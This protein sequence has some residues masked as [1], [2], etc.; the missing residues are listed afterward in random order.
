[1]ITPTKVEPTSSDTHIAGVASGVWSVQ[2]QLEAR[3]GGTWPDANVANPDTFIENNFSIDLW[4][5]NAG[6][7]TITNGIDL[8]NK[9]GLVWL[10]S[11][12]ST[13]N[14]ILTDSERGVTKLVNSNGA[15]AEA[16]N[17][18][19]SSFNS[20]GF[21]L[22]YVN[23]S[24]NTNGTN[25]VSWTF[26][27]APKFFDIQTWTQGSG[28]YVLSHNLGS[29]PGMVLLK[30][31]NASQDWHVYHRGMDATEPQDYGMRLNNTS[32]RSDGSLLWNDTA[33]TST[34]FTVGNHH[35][36][37]TYVAY[38]FAHETG[39]DSM[40]QCGSYTGNGN[41]TGPV[42]NLGFEPQWLFIKN[43]SSSENW[44]IM[45]SMRNLSVTGYNALIPNL[46]AAE[47]TSTSQDWARATSTGFSIG[48]TSSEI[49]ENNSNFIYVA[50]RREDMAT[51]TDATEVFATSIR[52]SS[53]GEGKYTSGFPVDFSIATTYDAT[54]NNFAFTR[55][56]N[57]HLQTN[58]NVAEATSAGDVAWDVM[59]GFTIGGSGLNAFFGGSTDNINYMW[60]RAK[61]YFDVV[62]VIGASGAMTINHNL[63]V[64]PEFLLAKRRDGTSH[65]YADMV[66]NYLRLN[67]DSANLGSTVFSNFTST[68]FQADSGTFSSGESWIVYL[69]AT[70]AG[71]S[72]VGS[73]THSGSSTDV[74]CGFTAGARLVMLK[75]TDATGDWYWWDST[76]GIIAGNDPYL[77]LNDT[78]AQVTNTDY[79]DPLSS[80]FTITGDFTDGDYI[81]YAIA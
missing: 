1:M 32:A 79:I 31:T 40:I 2:D 34:T 23:G 45:D 44:Q 21:S 77:L 72:K 27:K 67:T 50:I 69:F 26:K 12:S 38:L 62:A 25:Y 58:A 35:G 57:S 80:G 63:G 28:E 75:R 71:V 52:S 73:V 56:T 76:N 11:R 68:T 30:Q 6:T 24:T 18:D 54:S 13:E 37:G 8:S 74:D 16:S 4:T 22:Q 14:N 55:L 43:T 51:I 19:I 29:V 41:T 61:G 33:P 48:H 65:W 81:F 15:T 5:G 66:N 42:I 36:A 9:G 49:N 60:K 78:A 53:D 17:S 3:R 46:T 70:L 64:A 10:K 7:Q 20:D 39:S 47:Q 59:D